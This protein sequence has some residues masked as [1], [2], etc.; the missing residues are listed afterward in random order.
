MLGPIKVR[1]KVEM[2]MKVIRTDGRI[3]YYK[4][5]KTRIFNPGVIKRFINKLIKK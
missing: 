3:Q 4:A 5:N 1:P 2:V